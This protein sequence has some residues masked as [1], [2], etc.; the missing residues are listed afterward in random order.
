MPFRRESPTIE[1]R[2]VSLDP[3]P[4]PVKD[5]VGKAVTGLKEVRL[6]QNL[7]VPTED[8]KSRFIPRGEVIGISIVPEH[9]RKS[10]L[11][12]APDAYREN[13]IMMLHDAF[14]A[15]PSFDGQSTVWREKLFPAFSLVDPASI[16]N[17]IMEGLIEGQDYLSQW[18]EDDRRLKE[19]GRHEAEE[20]FPMEP[21]IPEDVSFGRDPHNRYGSDSL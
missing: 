17:R 11:I 10:D 1:V 4:P 5:P 19:A 12:E 14:F 9:L 8:G 7:I 2:K 3:L 13:K 18:D 15:V 20:T 16:P 6:L 21:D